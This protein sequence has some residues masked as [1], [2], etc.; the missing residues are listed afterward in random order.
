[1]FDAKVPTS[2]RRPSSLKPTAKMRANIHYIKMSR[3]MNDWLQKKEV[4]W[5]DKVLF[6]SINS[7]WRLFEYY[8]VIS[9]HNW[10]LSQAENINAG[11]FKGGVIGAEKVALCHEPRIPKANRAMDDDQYVVVDR[12]TRN[13]RTPDIVIELESHSQRQLLVFDA[14]CRQERDVWS[15]LT[16]C[17]S[18]YTNAIR[19]RASGKPIVKSLVMLYPKTSQHKD[20]RFQDYYLEP[21]RKDDH[22]FAEPVMGI[23]RILIEK[24]GVEKSY[25]ELLGTLFEKFTRRDNNAINTDLIKV[26]G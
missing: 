20:T 6:S 9:T 18:K 7:T 22:F 24:D 10:L 25:S 16:M 4:V 11:L 26:I 21:Y 14:K 3:M 5:L 12:F 13:L 8:T 17:E 15:D 1:M 2:K 19:D 23:Q